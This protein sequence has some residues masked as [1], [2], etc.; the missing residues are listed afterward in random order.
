MLYIRCLCCNHQDLRKQ[1]IVMVA[2]R[3]PFIIFAP[4]AQTLFETILVM[5]PMLSFLCP[6]NNLLS[7]S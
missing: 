3:K 4:L 7:V 1:A 2:I 5:D 6:K